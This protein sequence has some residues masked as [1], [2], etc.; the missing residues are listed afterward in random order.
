MQTQKPH[1]DQRQSGDDK[2]KKGEQSDMFAVYDLLPV[3]QWCNGLRQGRSCRVAKRVAINGANN[4][5]I[6]I[7][8]AAISTLFH[9]SRMND[10]HGAFVFYYCSAL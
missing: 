8:P 5:V 1:A 6:G 2:M 10:F 3:I 7:F 4:R 9:S